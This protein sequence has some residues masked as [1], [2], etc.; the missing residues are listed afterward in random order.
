MKRVAVRTPFADHRNSVSELHQALG[1]RL[2]VIADGDV[3]TPE[4]MT[5]GENKTHYANGL[6]QTIKVLDS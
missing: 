5:M 1:S 2:V 6:R 4:R 3:A